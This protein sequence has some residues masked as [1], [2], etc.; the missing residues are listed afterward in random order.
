LNTT[1]KICQW[2]DRVAIHH[3]AA[4]MA[5]PDGR[6]SHLEEAR[7]LLKNLEFSPAEIKPA[8]VE[9]HGPMKFQFASP[10]PSA[11]AANNTVHGRLY[12]CDDH[13]RQKPTVLLL[14]GW[15]DSLNHYYYFP[16]HARRLNRIGISAATLQLP[17]QFNRR[18]RQLG[19]WGNFLCADVLHT[20]EATLQAMADIR[21]FIDWLTLQACPFVGLW[22][23]SMGAWLAGLTLCHDSR[24]ACAVLTVPVAHL[25]R[26]IEEA[27][28]CETIRRALQNQRVDLHKL[29][30]VSSR[31]L[32][33]KENILLV[34][35]EHDLFVAKEN[36][37]ELWRAWD[38]PE[39]WRFRSGHISVLWVPGLS[40][41]VVRWIAA[42]AEEHAAK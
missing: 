17:W 14:H 15:N 24:V 31:P 23:V 2:I 29:N 18:P 19:P 41:R 35:A 5:K 11:H 20:V 32:V 7:H 8:A 25:D 42:K 33:A 16:R 4:R 10:H 27:A 28:F 12:R 6:D 9:F 34:E 37:E 39:I 1:R 36:V 38:K 40:K 3:A 13:W 21:A 22:G 30:L 26:L